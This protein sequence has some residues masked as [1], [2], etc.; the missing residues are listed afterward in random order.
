[1]RYT[2]TLLIVV[3]VRKEGKITPTPESRNVTTVPKPKR[4]HPRGNLNHLGISLGPFDVPGKVSKENR[5]VEWQV[6]SYTGAVV[7]LV[8]LHATKLTVD[9]SAQLQV[10]G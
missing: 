4:R 6:R 1:M 7:T 2:W 5:K 10:F 3:R 8:S 9:L